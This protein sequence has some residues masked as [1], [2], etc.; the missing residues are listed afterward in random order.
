MIN[1]KTI[2]LIALILLLALPGLNASS[3]R[4]RTVDWLDGMGLSQ[5]LILLLISMLPVI[6]LRGSIPVGIFLFK[7]PWPE[8]VLICVIGNMLPLPFVLL[9]IEGF[10]KYISRW[11]IGQGFTN[12]LYRRATNKGKAIQRYEALGLILFV[13]VP[14][15]GTGGWTGSFAAKIFGIRFWNALL[16]V[17]LGVLIAAAIVTTLCLTGQWT[18]GQ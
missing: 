8:V 6:E 18:L 11:K 10:L 15:P 17:F 2:L 16:Y 14:L 4:E 13:G 9:F 7:L 12:W 5:T 3:F 1:K